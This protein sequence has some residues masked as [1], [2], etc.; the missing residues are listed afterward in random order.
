MDDC[1]QSAVPDYGCSISTW[2][3]LNM[4][5]CLQSAV[6]D[7]GYPISTWWLLN[8]D[9]CLQSA[10][11]DYGYPISTW[12]L[13][14]MD[15]CL[16]SA[17]PDCLPHQRMMDAKHGWLLTVCS[18]RLRLSHQ[19][20]MDAKHGW[21]QCHVAVA[22]SAHDGCKTW[23][24]AMPCY[25]CPISTWWMQNMDDCNAMLQ[26]PHQHMMDA[27]HGWLFAV[28]DCSCPI[29]TWWM[30][31]MDDC[32]AR[33]RLSHQHICMQN[34]V[35][36]STRLLLSHQHMLNTKHGWLSTCSLECQIMVAPSVH[37]GCKRWM[38]SCLQSAVLDCG[39]PISTC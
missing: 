20:M 7:Y 14:N 30:Q 11:P 38:T 28:P 4:D 32:S 1:L 27:K 36:C 37:D 3:L 19:H 35:N 33:L 8:M 29:S 5:D 2:W 26:L 10:V 15:D 17:V 22:P 39:C 34:M 12:W 25:G 18:A 6:P 13:L 9:D 23:M 31:N 16:Q 21:L 24:T